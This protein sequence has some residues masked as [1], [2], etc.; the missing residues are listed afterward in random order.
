GLI[1]TILFYKEKKKDENNNLVVQSN[2]ETERIAS[3]LIG[4][5]KSLSEVSDEVFSMKLMGEGIA[6]E[7]TEGS[8]YAPFDGT[9]TTL[10]PTKHAIG[11]TS[12]QGVEVLIHIGIDTDELKGEGFT[13]Y[14][15]VDDK[16]QKGQKLIDFDIEYIKNKGYS[17]ETPIIVTNS[18]DMAAINLTEESF[19]NKDDFIITV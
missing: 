6:I 2:E 11:I 19:V 1:L 17:L 10:F 7:P 9:I 18:K 16:I 14:V 5:T 15:E 4:N 3:P 8:I 13:K 12:D